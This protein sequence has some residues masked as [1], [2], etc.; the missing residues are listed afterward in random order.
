MRRKWSG[1][2][3]ERGRRELGVGLRVDE[4]DGGGLSLHAHIAAENLRG[5]AGI[6]VGE[7]EIGDLRRVDGDLVAGRGNIVGDPDRIQ[8]G[9]P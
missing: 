9:R 6:D 2:R 4:G 8:A 1:R 7:L 5:L 3:G